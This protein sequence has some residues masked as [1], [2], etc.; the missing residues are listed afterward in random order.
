MSSCRLCGSSATDLLLD[1]G[2]RS[3]HR[4][5]HHCDECDLVYVP[6][7]FLLNPA[8]ERERYLLHENEAEDEGYRTFLSRL[9]DEVT[10]VLEPNAE[11]LDYGCGDPPV[12]V[13]ILRERGFHVEG[14][15][16][17]FAPDRAPLDRTYD[18]VTCSETAEHF[19]RPLIEFERFDRLLC[20]GGVL[21]VMTKMLEDQTQ[22]ADWHYRYD[23][24]HISYFSPTTM[25]WIAKRFG[26][27]VEFP[28]ETVT[29]FRKP[30][31]EP[32]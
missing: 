20:P 9:A 4:E 10:P 26:W 15:D 25:R 13:M 16:L 28:R 27:S 17:Y 1:G 21:G 24:T 29:I 19:R 3:H 31:E 14:W 2:V 8:D 6:D 30:E 18:F 12:L 22:F 11:G 32:S 7:R 23:A 5:F